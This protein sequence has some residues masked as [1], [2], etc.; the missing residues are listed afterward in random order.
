MPQAPGY[1]MDETYLEVMEAVWM[2]HASNS[3]DIVSKLLHNNS[4]YLNLFV[5]V[6]ILGLQRIELWHLNDLLY[7]LYAS[8]A[9]WRQE[10][11]HG[12]SL[13]CLGVA[14]GV[15]LCARQS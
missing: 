6:T 10:V 12:L 9:F 14:T 3:P 11:R 2:I 7:L 4:V 13:R 5:V 15:D 8:L 1:S